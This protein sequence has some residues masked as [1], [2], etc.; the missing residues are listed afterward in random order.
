M[1]VVGLQ[2]GSEIP[3]GNLNPAPPDIAHDEAQTRSPQSRSPITLQVDQ[4]AEPEGCARARAWTYDNA[5]LRQLPWLH[6]EDPDL[7]PP[8]DAAA[9]SYMADID[10]TTPEIADIASTIDM[11]STAAQAHYLNQ[12]CMDLGPQTSGCCAT[13]AHPA[14]LDAAQQLQV[15]L[16]PVC[17]AELSIPRCRVFSLLALCPSEAFTSVT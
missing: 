1:P 16:V 5:L 12:Q 13:D 15:C 14:Q 3:E 4:A 11:R 7:T 9:E 2:L 8:D 17:Q 10:I 6:D